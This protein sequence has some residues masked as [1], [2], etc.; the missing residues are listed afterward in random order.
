MQFTVPDWVPEA[1]R[2]KIN[3]LHAAPWVDD[4]GRA[5]LHRLATYAAMKTE[6]WQKLPSEPKGAEGEIIDRVVH[7]VAIFP[8][9]RRPYPK[10]AA[11][12][13][14]WAKHIELHAATT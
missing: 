7:A 14:E 10:T 3:A 11:K 2:R 1:A 9:L 13:R 4:N 5:L 6:V 8:R 12:R